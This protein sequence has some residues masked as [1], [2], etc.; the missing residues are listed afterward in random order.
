[1]SDGDVFKLEYN[2]STGVFT[3]YQN[4]TQVTQR[5]GYSQT[6]LSGVVGGKVTG[7][8]AYDITFAGSS[9]AGGTRLPPPPIV[10]NF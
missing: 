7:A 8:G 5:S 2:V 1:M 4:E 3:L 9:S 6:S 10:V